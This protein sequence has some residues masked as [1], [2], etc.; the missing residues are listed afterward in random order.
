MI[1]TEGLLEKTVSGDDVKVTLVYPQNPKDTYWGF[2]RALK[3]VGKRA[4]SPPLGLI[5]VAGLLPENYHCSLIDT[6]IEPLTDERI[7]R[8]DIV[9]LSGIMVQTQSIRELIQRISAQQKTILF[10]GPYATKYFDAENGILDDI[11]DKVVWVL[12]E[13]ENTVPLVINDLQQ[14][15]LKNMYSR[16]PNHE[17]LERILKQ[18]EG[19]D[20]DAKVLDFSRAIDPPRARYDLV[21]MDAYDSMIL[22]FSRGCPGGCEFCDVATLFGPKTRYRPSQDIVDD[23][24]TLYTLGWRGNVVLA[25]DNPIGMPKSANAIFDRVAKFQQ[26]RGH[27]FALHAEISLNIANNE[28]M[29]RNYVRAGGQVIFVG[30]ETPNPKS[31]AET[32]KRFN[33]SSEVDPESK[34]EEIVEKVKILQRYVEVTGGFIIGFDSDDERIFGWQ[35]RLVQESG[36]PVAMVGLLRAGPGTALYE[37]M[38]EEGRLTKSCDGSNTQSDTTNFLTTM[39]TAVLAREY[40]GLLHRLYSPDLGSYFE[41]VLTMFEHQRG[42]HSRT[43]R[44]KEDLFAVMRSVQLFSKKMGPNYLRFLGKT[45]LKYPGRIS[46]AIKFGIYGY[47]LAEITKNGTYQHDLSAHVR[48]QYEELQG[49]PIDKLKNSLVERMHSY[50]TTKPADYQRRV[51]DFLGGVEKTIKGMSSSEGLHL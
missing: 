32:G 42:R 16:T 19:Q 22:Q 33:V 28:G 3:F 36:I 37:R 13:G 8:S 2:E 45:L 24:G 35:E 49:T 44:K 40:T 34:I 17:S 4:P 39:D 29:L 25:D 5:T 41:R 48:L 30:I 51:Q 14:G 1:I 26:E 20:V 18:F 6:N 23:F 31:L 50:V 10:G 21:T 9:L 15:H 7:A 12:N 47:H 46:D 27:P 11:V 38:E 43:I